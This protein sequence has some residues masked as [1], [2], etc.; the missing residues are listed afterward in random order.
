VTELPFGSV[1]VQ[2]VVDAWFDDADA[3][4][5]ALSSANGKA[6][7]RTFVANPSANIEMLVLNQDEWM[8]KPE[9]GA[10]EISRNPERPAPAIDST[11]G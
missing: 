1:R 4:N 7:A 10:A 2:A 5:A 11:I 8:Q 6:L 9:H 3:M